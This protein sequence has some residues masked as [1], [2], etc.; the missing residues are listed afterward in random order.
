MAKAY[1]ILQVPCRILVFDSKFDTVVVKL[2]EV[3]RLTLLTSKFL[4]STRASLAFVL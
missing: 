2:Q 3:L 1:E 4:T